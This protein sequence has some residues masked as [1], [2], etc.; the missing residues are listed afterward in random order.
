M[1][2]AFAATPNVV[3]R[4]YGSQ[5]MPWLTTWGDVIG[6]LHTLGSD[7]FVCFGGGPGSPDEPC[8]VDDR[9]LGAEEDIPGEAAARGWQTVLGKDEI[10]GIIDNLFQQVNVRDTDLILHAVAYYVD[11]DAYWTRSEG[12]V[13]RRGD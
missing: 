2:N 13:R 8:L 12:P 11:H 5:D 3:Q 10:Q 1:N 4:P 9:E 6:A 7:H